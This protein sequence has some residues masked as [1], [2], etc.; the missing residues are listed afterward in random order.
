MSRL[1]YEY[2]NCGAYH[3]QENASFNAHVDAVGLVSK[4]WPA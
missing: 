2:M 3:K 1:I 4:F